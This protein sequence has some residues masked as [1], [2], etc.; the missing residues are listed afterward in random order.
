MDTFETIS[1][2]LGFSVA[3]GVLA[4]AVLPRRPRPVFAA[5]ACTALAGVW[6]REEGVIFWPMLPIGLLGILVALVVGDVLDGA[7]RRAALDAGGRE[8]K[9]VGSRSFGPAVV[10][11]AIAALIAV[12]AWL[13]PPTSLVWL[14]AVLIL[15]VRRRRSG[16]EKH[17]GL[18]ILR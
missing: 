13:V 9:S 7:S 1:Q 12:L 15:A 8:G 16:T 18:R 5:I 17:E 2:A 6:L 3:V 11:V 4:G 10:G 14:V